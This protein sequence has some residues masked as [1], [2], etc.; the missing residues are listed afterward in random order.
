MFASTRRS[1]TVLLAGLLGFGLAGAHPRSAAAEDA[2][3][4][5]LPWHQETWS[6]DVGVTGYFHDTRLR[7]DL[8]SGGS[9]TLDFEHDLGMDRF[10]ASPNLAAQWRF[11]D[12]K[13]HKLRVGYL[14]IFRDGD[15]DLTFGLDLGRLGTFPVGVRADTNLDLNLVDITYGY[16]LCLT[17]R[18][19][20]GLFLGL[21]LIWLDF[22]ARATVNGL[23]RRLDLAD[24]EFGI[25]FPTAGL[26]V[27]WAFTERLGFVTRL[28]YFGVQLDEISGSLFRGTF[29]MQHNTFTNVSFY[30]GYDL[31]GLSA[32][33]DLDN[34]GRLR[35]F[36][37]GPTLGA[38]FRF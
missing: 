34:T 37:H 11:T 9:K 17:E 29:R 24:T 28:Q 13:R 36:S 22:N 25:P 30:V 2:S 20:L 38:V 16:S 5:V 23:P 8:L 19:E 12:N 7:V 10:A 35:N 3:P 21:D 26:E 33:V 32:S 27:S 15:R 6:L 1:A 31:L 14:G 18:L 4:N